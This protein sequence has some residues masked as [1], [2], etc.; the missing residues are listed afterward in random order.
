[1]SSLLAQ[2]VFVP[3]EDVVY[4]FIEKMEIKGLTGRCF[5]SVKPIPRTEILLYL[6]S[7]KESEKYKNLSSSEKEEL[8]NYLDEY[9][10][11][12][13][14]LDRDANKLLQAIK[15]GIEYHGGEKVSV[16]YEEE[17]AEKWHPLHFPYKFLNKDNLLV[18]NP[19]FRFKY[20]N[21]QSDSS[22]FAENNRRLT[23]GGEIYGYLGNNIGFYF[24]GVNNAEWGNLY[25]IKK[26]DRQEQGI[27]VLVSGEDKKF[28]E[29]VDAYV[30]FSTKYAD[31]IIG[32]FSNYWG[33]GKTGSLTISNKPPSYPQ[34]MIRAAFSDWLKFIYFHGWLESNIIDT[35]LSYPYQW[36]ERKLYKKKYVA[37]H[38]LEITP[39]KNLKFGF[40][41]MLYYGERDPEPVYF[42]PI[43]LFWSA[44]HYSNDQD[45]EQIGIDFEWI[46]TY[47][48][49]LYGSIMV[50]E[51][52]L[53]KM[54]D[55]DE[56]RNQ[57][58]FQLGSYFVEP[59]LPGLDFRIEYTRLNPWTYTHKFPI[60]EAISDGYIMGYWTGQNADNLYLGIDYQF[61]DKLNLATNFSHYRKGAQDSIYYQYHTRP[62]TLP[63]EKF[64]Y[65]HQYTRNT[66]S[67]SL[68]YEIMN[69]LF[70][71]IGYNFLDCNVNETNI[72]KEEYVNPILYE[73]DFRQN[74]LVLSIGYGF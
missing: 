42:I 52:S 45:N 2:V 35:S 25:D 47:F 9:S 37:A 5:N 21:N 14:F 40:S 11:E 62:D 4:Q 24:R 38:R 70:C 73:S 41:E 51:I 13:R 34:I 23:G 56:A 59:F 16:Q 12:K 48:C 26:L 19:I 31:L 39:L 7:I 33:T 67:V 71:K 27:G 60:N 50:D 8:E 36:T 57:L 49:K 20:K 32:R 22:F 64:L 6:L 29:E 46:P 18:F 68:E 17:E 53:S 3:L 58:G 1:V 15:K 66:F 72:N 55:K 30:S 44:Q 43:I 10:Y 74:S 54:F 61:N 63:S 65:G 28:Y 69:N